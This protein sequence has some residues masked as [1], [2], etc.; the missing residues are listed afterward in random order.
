MVAQRTEQR[1]GSPGQARGGIPAQPADRRGT[2]AASASA[3]LP[4]SR[5]CW[6]ATWWRAGREKYRWITLLRPFQPYTTAGDIVV[7][8]RLDG[9]P[10]LTC[11][12]GA[13]S[14]S[15]TIGRWSPD[16]LL[17]GSSGSRVLVE[18]KPLTPF[19]ADVADK[20]TTACLE[21]KF[22]KELSAIFLLGVSPHNDND[23]IKI[24]WARLFDHERPGWHIAS[25]VWTPNPDYPEFWADIP[26]LGG[27]TVTSLCGVFSGNS[28][29]QENFRAYPEHTM[30]LWADASNR[31]QWN[32]RG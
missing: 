14:M 2:V 20:A 6:T 32:A 19:D 12:V 7:G 25:L 16:F 31:V 15:L 26:V 4:S 17:V 23:L 10:F 22:N 1:A 3:R 11:W 24:G 21:R 8:W 9:L 30:R 13:M 18:I 29:D 5:T 27:G 28:I